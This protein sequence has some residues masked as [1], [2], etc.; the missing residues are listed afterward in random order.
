MILIGLG[1]NMGN[2]QENIMTAIKGLSNH[3]EIRVDKISS[4]YETKPVG[5]TG[6]PDFLNGA[7][8]ISTTL[9][10]L[11]LL[12]V[13]L[14]VECEMGRIRKERWGPRNIDIDILLYQDRILCDERLHIPHPRLHTRS[15]VLVPLSEIASDL[16]VYQGLTPGQLLTTRS[17]RN[18][19]RLYAEIDI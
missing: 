1:S 19:V 16:P 10:P 13:C 3:P 12:E 11:K 7:I 5:V 4:L 6:Q 17:D 8:G 9:E 14:S 15:F 2:R 18:D